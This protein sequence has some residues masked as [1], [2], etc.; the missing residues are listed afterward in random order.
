M[1]IL[2]LNMFLTRCEKDEYIILLFNYN[3]LIILYIYMLIPSEPQPFKC[4]KD[5]YLCSEQSRRCIP[6]NKICDGSDDCPDA[7]DEGL[8]C[9]LYFVLRGC[10]GRCGGACGEV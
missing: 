5:E 6:S 9:S 10:G 3:M 7:T 1:F 4:E 8:A 2:H